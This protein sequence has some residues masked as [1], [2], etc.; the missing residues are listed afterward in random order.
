MVIIPPLLRAR[1]GILSIRAA[2]GGKEIYV[3]CVTVAALAASCL[4]ALGSQGLSAGDDAGGDKLPEPAIQFA[5]ETTLRLTE[6]ER[7]WAKVAER[8][9][10]CQVDFTVADRS[11]SDGS[12][13]DEA[14]RLLAA[15]KKLQA[16][17]KQMETSL[18]SFKDALKKASA[19][20]RE[21][22]SLYKAYAAKARSDEV[23]EDYEQLAKA[24]ERKAGAAAERGRKI[25]MP[26]GAEAKKEGIE[27]GNLFLERLLE[28]LGIGPMSDAE[29]EVF[30]GRLKKHGVRCKA[31]AEELRSGI[32]N[33]L[34]DS[35]TPEIRQKL[36]GA[37]KA[38]GKEPS[39]PDASGAKKFLG[40]LSGGSWSSPVTI[41]GVRYVTVVRFSKAGTCSQST[42]ILGP[43][44][45]RSRV[46][47]ASG[48]FDVDADGFLQF[49]QAGT[50]IEL[51]KVSFLGKDR[52]SYEILDRLLAPG[53]RGT[54][55]TFSREP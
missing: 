15:A 34:S 28:A 25:A 38:K 54:R 5:K 12:L 48:S 30:I 47:I 46:A 42:Y 40:L 41:D 6:A 33:L 36:G 26:S 21:V 3:R 14:G 17:E 53:I 37:A 13:R 4:L 35:E 39:P 18:D 27:E 8:L 45:K 7:E 10:K 49:Y 23:R 24:Y 20:Y 16:D 2:E 31:F 11:Y 51:G 22:A 29:R 52:W 9:D 44:G 19:H 43:N 50:P 55:L 32:E 1:R